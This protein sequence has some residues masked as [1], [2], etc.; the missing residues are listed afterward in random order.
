[1]KEHIE[2]LIGEALKTEP[3]F[4]LRKDFKDRVVRAI[5][6]QE[7]ASQRTIYVWMAL[8]AVIIFGFGYGIMAYFMPS[9]FENFKSLND[10]ASELILIAVLVG[11]II[12]IV[13]YLDKRLVKN[14]ILTT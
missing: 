6:K 12:V 11:M 5:R 13:Q 1:M 7:K 8:G 2:R 3:S 9:L 4:Q 14:K 10:G